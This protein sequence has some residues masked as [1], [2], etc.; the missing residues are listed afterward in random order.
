MEKIESLKQFYQRTPMVNPMKLDEKNGGL[1]H[2]NVFTRDECS[3][4]TAYSRRDYY[5]ISFI[6]GKGTLHYADKWIYIDRPALLFSNPKVPYAWEA[7]N[8]FQ[9]GWFCLFSESFLSHDEK[10]GSLQLSPLFQLHKRP[11]FFL[12][13]SQQQ[14]MANI[15]QFMLNEMT[16]EY[17]YRYDLIRSY[18]HVL[19]HEGMKLQEPDSFQITKN[20]SARITE[21]FL[22]LLERQFPVDSPKMRL[23]LTTAKIFAEHLSVHTNHLNRSVKAE[24]GCSTTQIIRERVLAESRALLHHTNWSISEIAYSLGFES[25]AYFTNFFKKMTDFTPSDYRKSIV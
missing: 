22:E 9:K 4:L 3:F 17:K 25:Q 11:V 10:F 6:I 18:L 23:E 21:L 1:G 15:F 13:E 8:S 20:A 5:K 14:Q 24:T 12:D 7:E 16:G 19:L 2:F